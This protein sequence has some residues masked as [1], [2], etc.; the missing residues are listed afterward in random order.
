MFYS[1]IECK[2]QYFCPRFGCACDLDLVDSFKSAL[3]G[4]HCPCKVNQ[5]KGVLNLLLDC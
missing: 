1:S 5:L 4:C 2:E 3:F